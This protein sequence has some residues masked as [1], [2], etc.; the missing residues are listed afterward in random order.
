MYAT[1]SKVKFHKHTLDTPYPVGPV[2]IYLLEREDGCILF[3][4][5]PPTPSCFE[6]LRKNIPLGRLKWVF[7]THTHADHCGAA[8]FLSSYSSARILMPRKDILKHRMFDRIQ[9]RLKELFLE[10]G[11]D[12]EVIKLMEKV[13]TSF[14]LQEKIPDSALAIEDNEIP[15]GIGYEPYPGHS[16]TDFVYLIE[17]EYAVTGDFLLSGIF[18]T[19]LIEIDPGSMDIFNTY[20]AYCNSI[21]RINKLNEY[22]IMPAHGELEDPLDAVRFYVE[23][24]LKRAE[25]MGEC[26]KA[27]CSVF[28]AVRRLVDPYKEPFKAYLKASELVFFKSFLD[29][30]TLLSV[31]LKSIGL[32]DYF[33]ERLKS[34]L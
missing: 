7:V 34:F 20:E 32:Y 33:E 11:F 23:K 2:H 25:F 3:D 22:R 10:M 8:E 27:G 14:K 5:G 17:K 29:N 15:E 24:L 19:P 6:Y 30:P 26:L 16:L 21:S 9:L 12:R 18:Q 4:T 28:E 13:L 1:P 31:A